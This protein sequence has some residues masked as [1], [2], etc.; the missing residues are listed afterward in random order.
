MTE[1][2]PLDTPSIRLCE[3]AV[4]WDEAS[5]GPLTFQWIN[6]FHTPSDNYRISPACYVGGINFNGTGSPGRC[7]VLH[8]ACSFTYDDAD[9][10]LDGPCYIDLPGGAFDFHVP[11]HRDV[12]LI[13]VWELPWETP[14][15]SA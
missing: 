5:E 14:A 9:I 8:G 12:F 15:T 10:N 6:S 13:R 4:S 11:E 2:R 3:T 7:Y 1:V